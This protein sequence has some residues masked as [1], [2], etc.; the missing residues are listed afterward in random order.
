MLEFDDELSRQVESTYLTPDIVAQRRVVLQTLAL[1]PG[2]RALDIGTGPGL[3][4]HEMA[5][6]LGSGGR[7]DGVDLS[8]SMLAIAGRRE[9]AAGAAP[10]EL[11]QVASLELPFAD[12]SFDVAVSTQVYEYVEDM[13]GALAEARR[14]LRPGGR[15]VVLDT[16]WDSIVWHA[17]DPERMRR[18]LA[19]WDEHLADAH[20]PRRLVRLLTDAGFEVESCTT[21]PLLNVGYDP[22]TYSAGLIEFIRSF[23]VGRAELDED[24]VAAWADDLVAL[25]PD[26]FF[27]LNRYLFAADR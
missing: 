4:A 2:E 3:L 7:V 27:S 11:H 12:A 17:T 22:R 10:V 21:T 9:P 23:V 19:V 25:G 13:P 16:D 14:V 24:E 18:V 1:R 15:M 5:A 6:V 20:L 26:Y 8:E